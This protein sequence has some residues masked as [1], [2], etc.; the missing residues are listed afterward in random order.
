MIFLDNEQYDI[1]VVQ[2]EKDVYKH[3][4]DKNEI[5]DFNN[6]YFSHATAER[7]ICGI[8]AYLTTANISN[9]DIKKH[10]TAL[11]NSNIK[12]EIRNSD[13]QEVIATRYCEKNDEKF[14]SK[15][16]KVSKLITVL[17]INKHYEMKK[18]R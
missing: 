8:D 12:I 7:I 3:A 4:V 13:T 2:K 5:S 1:V 6:Q 18:W 9:F 14:D 10:N 15:K 11:E 17:S 16:I